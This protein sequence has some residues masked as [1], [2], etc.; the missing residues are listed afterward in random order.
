MCSS[1]NNAQYIVGLGVDAQNCRRGECTDQAAD[2]CN[3]PSHTLSLCL[4]TENDHRSFKWLL[5]SCI[6]SLE[7]ARAGISDY[8][9]DIEVSPDLLFLQ[10]LAARL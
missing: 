2:P 10:G 3:G 8:K 4:Q 9:A 7:Q 5:S 6:R 1:L